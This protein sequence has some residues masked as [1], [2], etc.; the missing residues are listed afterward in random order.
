MRLERHSRCA[1]Q[2]H[3]NPAEGSL[4]LLMDL[5]A[6]PRLQNFFASAG[7][8]LQQASRGAEASG[9]AADCKM[10]SRFTHERDGKEGAKMGWRLHLLIFF[11]TDLSSVPKIVPTHRR[12]LISAY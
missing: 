9:G 8:R 4:P 10:A 12:H 11:T 6:T 2:L 5:Q 7:P 3:R 1:L